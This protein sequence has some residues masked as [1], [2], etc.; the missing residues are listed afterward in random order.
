MAF[1]ADG[2]GGAAPRTGSVA[3]H[4]VRHSKVN[5]TLFDPSSG[6]ETILYLRGRFKKGNATL[7]LGDDKAGQ[8]VAHSARDPTSSRK[9]SLAA[10]T[11]VFVTTHARRRCNGPNSRP[12]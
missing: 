2:Q 12:I 10:L 4:P 3:D 6:A 7:R 5:I 1:G 11:P 9:V 8:V